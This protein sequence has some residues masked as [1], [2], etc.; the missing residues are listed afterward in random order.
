MNIITTLLFPKLLTEAI[1]Y[2]SLI[3]TGIA[4]A[5]LLILLINDTIKKKIW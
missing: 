3:L 2:G 4:F 5:S 1:L